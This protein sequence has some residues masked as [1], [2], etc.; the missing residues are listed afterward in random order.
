MR[1]CS[2]EHWNAS[3]SLHFFTAPPG[4]RDG[5][6]AD[7]AARGVGLEAS[8]LSA[9]ERAEFEELGEKSAQH[10]TRSPGCI[11]GGPPI[12]D[13]SACSPA[14]PAA[15]KLLEAAALVHD[16]GH[17]VSGTGHHKHSAYLVANSDLPGFTS[18][19]KLAVAAL[20][21]F[22]RKA[23]PQP[24]KTYFDELDA[25]A[26]RAVT[27]LTPLLRLADSLDRSHE[28]KVKDLS[29]KAKDANVQLLVSARGRAQPGDL[30]CQRSGT[31]VQGSLRPRSD[32]TARASTIGLTAAFLLDL[33]PS[34]P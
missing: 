6:I 11:S 27:Y 5:I 16:I 12:R 33:L 17:F 25:D 7:L 15:G 4:V 34:E 8:R 30:G 14:A 22:H 18:R 31:H 28:Q 20:C 10:E 9:D 13:T 24:K 2:L 1:L 3:S 19:E 32:N 29:G 23:L 21:R 26:K